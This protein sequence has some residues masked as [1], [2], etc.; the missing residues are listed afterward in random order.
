MTITV[1][2]ALLTEWNKELFLPYALPTT[3]LMFNCFHYNEGNNMK[4]RLHYIKFY[5]KN[6]SSVSYYFSC[7]SV[8]EMGNKCKM[9]PRT[10]ESAK[11]TF[12]SLKAR[13][14]RQRILFHSHDCPVLQQSYLDTNL[15]VKLHSSIN[16]VLLAVNTTSKRYRKK[17]ENEL[18]FR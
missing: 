3:T 12:P 14:F 1:Y 7:N 13:Q 8:K 16:K 17:I 2:W 9:W 15:G 5:K 6:S 18:Q 10:S 4:C 11:V